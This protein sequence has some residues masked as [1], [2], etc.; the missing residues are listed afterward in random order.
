[1]TASAT[2][3]AP[4]T[5]RARAIREGPRWLNRQADTTTAAITHAPIASCQNGRS[6]LSR[7]SAAIPPLWH[8]V[9]SWNNA[10]RVDVVIL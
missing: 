2:M 3:A 1:M 4:V 10:C 6:M 8:A 7:A 9:V 5:T